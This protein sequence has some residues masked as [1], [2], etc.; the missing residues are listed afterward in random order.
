M[1]KVWGWAA[2]IVVLVL[3]VS[4]LSARTIHHNY[5]KYRLD[6]S[7]ELQAA[8]AQMETIQSY[9]YLLESGFTVDQRKEV[10]S[11]VEGEKGEGN[12]HIKGEMVNTP[13]DIYYI[14]KTIYNYDSFSQKW[15][16]IE[17]DTNNSEELLVSELNP[18]SNFRVKELGNVV[19]SGFEE[20][21]GKECLVVMCQP[22][23][24]SELLE[25]LWKEY[26]YRFWVDYEGKLIRKAALTAANKQSALTSLELKAHFFDFNN[27]IVIKPPANADHV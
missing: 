11:K 12:T 25:T 17:S 18:L 21:D 20:V 16:V 3:G 8:M 14:D 13:V 27:K 26:E 19:K 10:I 4:L 22:S 23:V 2:V 7:L 1:K 5:V 9:R 15:L 6:P 24:E